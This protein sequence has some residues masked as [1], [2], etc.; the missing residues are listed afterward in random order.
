MTDVKTINSKNTKNTKE[1]KNKKRFGGENLKWSL[2]AV[3]G[4]IIIGIFIMIWAGQVHQIDD[5]F[6]DIFKY[7]FFSAA[8][9]AN[10]LGNFGW[11]LVIG[12]ALGVAFRAGQFNIGAAGQMMAGGITAFLFASNIHM[13]K[14][15]VILTILIATITGALVAWVI[16][17]LKTQF[18]INVVISSIM[19][20]WIIFYAMKYV[21]GSVIYG[22][23]PIIAD[24]SLRMSWLSNLF[25][26]SSLVS[27]VNIGFIIAIVI[28]I[29]LAIAYKKTTWGYKQE[30]LGLNPKVSDYIGINK[31]KE[32]IKTLM[33]SGALAG[34]AG[35]IYYCGVLDLFSDPTTLNDLPGQGFQ[36]ITV[37][38]V[39]FSKSSRYLC[40]SHINNYDEYKQYWWNYWL[41]GYFW[42]YDCIDD[43][44]FINSTI[45]RCLQT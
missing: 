32:I 20:N 23:L 6:I 40:C 8:G 10:F 13:G 44:L 42:N 3:F 33:I 4:S 35:A 38:L 41:N 28:V 5:Y 2:L 25:N 7:N 43:Y 14:A 24:N 34:F 18:N 12:L 22:K 17:F 26:V 16:G 37:A 1:S 39:G 15:G 45:L 36:G 31:N 19:I 21:G 9:F 27:A 11:M 30:I 29:I